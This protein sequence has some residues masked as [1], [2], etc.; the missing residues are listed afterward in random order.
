[1]LLLAYGI[2]EYQLGTII[3]RAADALSREDVEFLDGSSDA[4]AGSAPS[5][6]SAR[7]SITG[8]APQCYLTAACLN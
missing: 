8:R 1:V 6:L 2:S 4:T 7:H 3:K 5:S